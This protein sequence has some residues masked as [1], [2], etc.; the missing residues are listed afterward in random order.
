MEDKGVTSLMGRRGVSLQATAGGGVKLVKHYVARGRETK[1]RMRLEVGGAVTSA[2]IENAATKL[3]NADLVMR[4]RYRTTE[5]T[6][7]N[8][9]TGL[10]YFQ[11]T[12]SRSARGLMF[13]DLKNTE[14]PALTRGQRKEK[15]PNIQL[16]FSESTDM[17]Q[18]LTAMR[19]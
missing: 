2:A 12:L 1:E 10:L 4:R 16:N 19:A 8:N 17:A 14:A 18:V 9:R 6:F 15:F 7:V 3:L 11:R 5:M 13:S